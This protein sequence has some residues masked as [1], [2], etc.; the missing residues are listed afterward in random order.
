MDTRLGARRAGKGGRGRDVKA[1]RS[2]G[3]SLNALMLSCPRS[4]RARDPGAVTAEPD[5]DARIWAKRSAGAFRTWSP[6]ALGPGLSGRI[7]QADRGMRVR[8]ARSL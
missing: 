2:C 4:F 1:A 3:Q 8:L 7:R 6:A 5:S